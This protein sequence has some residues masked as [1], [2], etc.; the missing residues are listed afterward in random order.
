MFSITISDE[1]L[2]K[3]YM[4]TNKKR[5]D[6][7]LWLLSAREDNK[8]FFGMTVNHYA[9]IAAIPVTVDGDNFYGKNYKLL[10][11]L[12]Q[13]ITAANTGRFVTIEIDDE[14]KSLAVFDS[15]GVNYNEDNQAF[16]SS[17]H[18]GIHPVAKALLDE[19]PTQ[20]TIQLPSKIS[21]GKEVLFDINRRRIG[22]YKFKAYVGPDFSV[23]E[24]KPLDVIDGQGLVCYYGNVITELPWKK[25]NIA[26]LLKNEIYLN[27]LLRFEN[28]G[29]ICVVLPLS[30]DVDDTY[31][32]KVF[33]ESITEEVWVEE[34]DDFLTAGAKK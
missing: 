14:K 3:L 25:G 27:T 10:N 26:Q 31:Y 9:G 20:A 6:S 15:N 30:T 17:F 33:G 4:A 5:Y 18:V 13:F 32:Q 21:K 34:D 8:A 22:I 11:C 28:D 2:T 19:Y 7:D 16:Q 23:K 29:V 24:V 12:Q 1:N